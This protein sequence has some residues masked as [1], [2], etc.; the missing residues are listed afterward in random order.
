MYNL[1]LVTAR[2]STADFIN[3]ILKEQ[4]NKFLGIG[5]IFTPPKK[6]IF[7]NEDDPLCCSLVVCAMGCDYLVGG[8]KGYGA[9]LLFVRQI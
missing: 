1:V 4:F 9:S 6:P 7:E 8:Q 2:E 5:H 3:T